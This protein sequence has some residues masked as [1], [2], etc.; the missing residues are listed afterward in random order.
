MLEPGRDR[1]LAAVFGRGRVRACL[2][3]GA[4]PRRRTR[5][6]RSSASPRR[7]ARPG[8]RRA[9]DPAGNMT[10]VPRPDDP[11][12][13]YAATY[14]AWNR[15]V[16]L[17]RR[18]RGGGATERLRRAGFSHQPHDAGGETRHFLLLRAT[19]G[20]LEERVGTLDRGRGASVRVGDAVR[21]RTGPAGPG[22]GRDRGASNERLYALQ[23][24]NWNVAAL[25]DD[26]GAVRERYGYAAYGRADRADPRVG[27]RGPA[28]TSTGR[29]RYAG[30]RYDP[31]A[32]LYHV[33]HRTLAP[34]V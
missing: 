16:R 12:G 15:L 1:Q 3:P 4:D 31:A 25:A 32:G 26:A 33:R 23:D 34:A 14:D 13:T 10:S 30:Y 2:G 9:Y 28:A 7:P 19:G 29:P 18:R 5:S 11:T 21:G 20:C 22:R 24:A 8:P 6:T 27:R 17:E